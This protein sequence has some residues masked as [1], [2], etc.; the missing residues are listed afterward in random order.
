MT[1]SQK[2]TQYISFMNF[3]RILIVGLIGLTT[4]VVVK[5]MMNKNQDFFEDILF[6]SEFIP[7]EVKRPVQNYS[8]NAPREFKHPKLHAE[9]AENPL[10]I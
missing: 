8:E 5:K 6:D 1:K 4:A 7:D 2:Q 9:D 10:F 3:S